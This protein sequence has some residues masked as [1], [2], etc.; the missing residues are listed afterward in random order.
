MTLKK[1]HLFLG[2]G[3]LLFFGLIAASIAQISIW[4]DEGYTAALIAGS[5]GDILSATMLDVHPPLYYFLLKTWSLLFGDSIVALRLFS[6]VCMFGAMLIAYRIVKT[7]FS[8]RAANWSFIAMAAGPFLVRY[9]QE[10]RMYGLGALIAMA[11]TWLFLRLLVAKKPSVY[12]WIGYG[13]LIALGMY[14]QYFFV[15]IPFAHIA[16]YLMLQQGSFKERVIALKPALISVGVFALLYAVWVPIVLSQFGA[17]YGGF[18]IGPNKIETLTSTFISLV[19][20][21]KQF[22]LEGWL[23]VLGLLALGVTGYLIYRAYASLPR[24]KKVQKY[25]IITMLLVPPLVLFALSLPPL[26]PAYQ[27]RYLSFT[28]PLFYSVLV[29]GIL[30]LKQRKAQIIA[31]VFLA[32]CF[33]YG[34]GV[35]YVYSNN[36][37]WNPTPYFTI[38]E[39]ASHI[40]AG[41]TVY[42]TSLW[43]Y[44]DADKKLQDKNDVRLLLDEQPESWKGNWSA[45]KIR[46][47]DIVT[48]TNAADSFWVIDEAN[49]AVL[50]SKHVDGY[51]ATESH[52]A[53]YATVTLYEK[54]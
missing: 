34:Q 2:A 46:Q 6:A 9:G 30:S 7:Y 11:A 20:L 16:L 32:G 22:M 3:T 1:S 19:L 44:F 28:A 48:H 21:A 5:Y 49:N 51:K 43:T 33:V 10:M 38:N 8:E 35:N 29:I 54:E 13:V 47:D 50:N 36:I 18:W 24:T 42:S 39:L 12:G 23:S 31:A 25:L 53:G 45:M 40:P 15:L 17:T 4:H 14:T 52:E 37:G 26:Q 27:D 41:D